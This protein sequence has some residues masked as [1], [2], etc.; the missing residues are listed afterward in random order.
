MLEMNSSLVEGQT[1]GLAWKRLELRCRGTRVK[2]L[3]GGPRVANR[4]TAREIEKNE[5]V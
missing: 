1:V 2:Q 5:D 3:G 4:K